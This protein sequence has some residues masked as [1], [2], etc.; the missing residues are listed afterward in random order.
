MTSRGRLPVERV[1][2]TLHVPVALLIVRMLGHRTHVRTTA[3][4]FAED[5]PFGFISCFC[6]AI[7][8]YPESGPRALRCDRARLPG[9]VLR[10]VLIDSGRRAACAIAGVRRTGSTIAQLPVMADA[11]K[12]PAA[13]CAAVALAGTADALMNCCDLGSRT[14][15]LPA[16]LDYS[17]PRRP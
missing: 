17:R 16:V 15:D 8:S 3:L 10:L 9:H 14:F 12:D 4:S 13:D 5:A 7:S 11:I 6:V 1:H 2:E